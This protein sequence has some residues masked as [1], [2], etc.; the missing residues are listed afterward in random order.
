MSK[1]VR[2]NLSLIKQV[3]NK[4][5]GVPHSKKFYSF[6]DSVRAWKTE[7][8]AQGIRTDIGQA[9][10]FTQQKRPGAIVIISDGQHN[11]KIYPLPLAQSI[12]APIYTIG[13]GAEQKQDLA[14]H[15]LRK[16]V[17]SFLGDT[18]E[19]T[20]RIQNKGFFN[21]RTK[22]SLERKGKIISSQDIAF[23]NKDVVQE[24]SFKVIPETIGKINYSIKIDDLP[25]EVNYANNRR[26]FNLE[27]IKSRWQILY[28]TNAPSFNTRFIISSLQDYQ[29]TKSD[30]QSSFSI[31][32]IIG[33]TGRNLK[34]LKEPSIEKAFSNADVVILD[35][36][37]EADLNSD[38]IAKLRN[39]I[40]QNKGF[41]VLTGE[42]FSPKSFLGE[43]LPFEFSGSNI[44]RKDLFIE[45]TDVGFGVPIFFSENNEYLLD[46]T[47]PLWG[48]NVAQTIK[49]NAVVWAKAKENPVPL[50][51]Y[52]Q[53]KNSKIVLITSFPLWRV[54]FSSIETEK[55]KQRFNQF[56]KNLI[57]FLGIKESDAF[58]LL[59]D[60]PDYLTG[61]NIIFN[62]LAT[63]PDGRNWT[64]LDVNIIIPSLKLS[65]PLYE[66]NPGTYEGYSEAL[67]SGIYDAEAIISKDGKPISKAKTTFSVT[68]QSIED[69]VGL[70]SDLL[71][72][73]ANTTN[74]K[75]YT[76]D[77]FL[78]ESF[79][80]EIIR[81]KKTLSFT[82]HN[83]LLVYIVVTILFGLVL[84]LRKKRGF[85]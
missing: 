52:H 41:L 51:G 26:D 1:S 30:V 19:I 46:N 80:P 16:P 61:E 11:G 31:I 32:P 39:L 81:Y 76:A 2:D 3:I 84:F 49:P 66:S 65:I 45:L 17:R 71:I 18:I 8:L 72:K 60:K 25:D 22:V 53:Y 57:R 6:S 58:K 14:I 24:I 54:G 55:T 47:P 77:E 44:Q 67:T 10:N 20:G 21:H 37:N 29:D 35:N 85:L 73:L 43:I 4:I 70:N 13:I 42:S 63:T 9:L 74:G 33:F 5:D 7:Q 82:F 23:S 59:T 38:I 69:I 48:V 36:I 28:L 34:I 50:I 62:L 27:I 12:H 79:S 56:L 83:N 75:Y 40:D 68:Q 64:D 15:S 78:K